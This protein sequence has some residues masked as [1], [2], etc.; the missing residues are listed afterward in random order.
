[1][2]IEYINVNC[3]QGP[4]GPCWRSGNET[5]FASIRPTISMQARTL[6][7]LPTSQTSGNQTSSSQNTPVMV[8]PQQQVVHTTGTSGEAMSSS[9]T[10]SHTDY[11]PA[12]SSATPTRQV[13]VAPPLSVGPHTASDAQS[14]QV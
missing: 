3:L 2:N 11:M 5:P 9:P 10:S 6:A 12:T 8:L 1:M 13:V 14:T 7:V 4:V